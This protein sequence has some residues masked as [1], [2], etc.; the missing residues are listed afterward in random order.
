MVMMPSSIDR[1]AAVEQLERMLRSDTFRR[2]ERSS[3]LLRFVVERTLAGGADQ[4]KE[5]KLGLGALGRGTSFDPRTDPI[6]RAEASRLRDR[7]ERYY[8]SEGQSDPSLLSLPKGSYVTRFE[9]RARG[10]A[11]LPATGAVQG[12][13]VA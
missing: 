4:L 9:T 8:D 2:S 1:T 5:Y 11:S 6:V 13:E 3:A 12:T 10:D 7:L